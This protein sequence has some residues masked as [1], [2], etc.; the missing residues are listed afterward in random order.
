MEHRVLPQGP[1]RQQVIL[2]HG[3]GANGADLIG[4]ADTWK[5]ALPHCAFLS[6]DAPEHYDM[7]PFGRQWFSLRDRSYEAMKAGL[8]KVRVFFD[9]YLDGLLREFSLKPAQCALVGFSQG[10][11]VALYAGLRHRAQLAGI[12]SYSGALYGAEDLAMLADATKPP[13]CFIHGVAD[14]VVPSEASHMADHALKQMGYETELHL[15]Q[16]VG[17]SIDDYGLRKGAAFLQRVLA[18]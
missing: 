4:L 3:V 16:G 7:A 8:H 13:V 2:L 5:E 12:L 11:M 9:H 14:D 17:H 15:C 6:P 18:A 1:V 10:A